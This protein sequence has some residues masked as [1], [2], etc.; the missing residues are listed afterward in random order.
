MMPASG[1]RFAGSPIKRTGRD[2]FVRNVL[3]AIGNSGEPTLRR[4]VEE[5]LA[6][7]SPLVRAMAVWALGGLRGRDAMAAYARAPAGRARSRDPR[8]MAGR[9]RLTRRL[10]C[11]GL[12]YTAQALARR[13]IAEGWR[14]AGTTR[15]AD[16]QAHLADE[17]F[18]CYG[19]AATGRSGPRCGARRHDPSLDLD[20]SRTR[21]GSGARASSRR[22]AAVRR[23][24]LGG[25][26]RAPPVSTAIAAAPGSTRRMPSPP[27]WGAR[28][29]G[30]AAEGHWLASGLPAHIFR[31][32]GIYGPGPGRNA[33]D[34]V[35]AGTA[36]R[37]VK[38]G[39]VFGRVH[40]DDIVQ[41]L[42]RRLP[43]PIPGAISTSPTTS[44]RRPRT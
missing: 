29:A 42:A 34:A 16:E 17:S 43:D 36:R 4:L 44:P 10:F 12:G 23:P 21:R 30:S 7:P 6:D 31:L 41:V 27:P 26:S 28:A 24:G 38:P 25:L 15:A 40:V 1:A 22:S 11:F 32:A 2:R 9:A 35:R 33:L 3:I 37:I 19:F 5:R 8:G 13:L 18:E 14:I 39:Q 20:R